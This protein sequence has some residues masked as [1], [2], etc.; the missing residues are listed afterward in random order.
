MSTEKSNIVSLI[1][2]SGCIDSGNGISFPLSI[3][4]LTAFAILSYGKRDFATDFR[5]KAIE[6]KKQKRHRNKDLI[7]LSP[8]LR[9]K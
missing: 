5:S 8:K 1:E 4:P 7:I 6:T 3:Q 2:N 9:N